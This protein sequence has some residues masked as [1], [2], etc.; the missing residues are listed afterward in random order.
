MSWKTTIPGLLLL[1]AAT[2]FLVDSSVGIVA[3][4]WPQLERNLSLGPG[5][6]FW[7]VALF[8]AATSFT[9]LLFAYLGDRTHS[10]WL[11]MAGPLAA[12]VAMSCV[13]LASTPM[14][15]AALLTVGGLGVAAFHPEAVV[16]AGACTPHHRSRAVSIF[17]IGGFLG[18][19]AGPAYSGAVVGAIGMAGLA[20]G[21]VWGVAGLLLLCVGLLRMP[22][23]VDQQ[24]PERPASRP[25]SDTQRARLILV[26]S[27]QVLRVVTAIGISLAL[28]FQ[29]DVRGWSSL[30]IGLIQSAFLGGIGAG[31][32]LC[33]IFVFQERERG[34]L[35]SLP[36]CVAPLVGLMAFVQG[37]PLIVSAGGSGVLLGILLPVTISYAQQLLPH[38]QRVASSLT[39]GVSWGVGGAVVAG[40]MLL[41]KSYGDIS[42][43][44][45]IFALSSALSGVLAVWLPRLPAATIKFA[46]ST[47]SV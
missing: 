3:P 24:L 5:S 18:Q 36:V 16:M 32:V 2:H 31:G 20:W 19:A 25:M 7:L 28:A 9:Q 34:V 22:R 10:G 33:A 13:G 40:A 4:L 12:I 11:I 39:M 47:E 1:L 46:G 15:A 21:V 30:Q 17:T 37:F 38:H 6:I 35:L 29:L 41:L 45:L 8:H 42:T 43:A 26:M 27:I 14:A 23:E 44:F